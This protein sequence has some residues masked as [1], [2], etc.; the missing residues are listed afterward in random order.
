MKSQSTLNKNSPWGHIKLELSM[1][2]I[3][4]KL[5]KDVVHFH[6]KQLGKFTFLHIGC[7]NRKTS[8]FGFKEF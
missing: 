3:A 5:V 2:G 6:P 1:L 8:K 7:P 4:K